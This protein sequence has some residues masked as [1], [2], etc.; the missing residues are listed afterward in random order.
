MASRPRAETST[1]FSPPVIQTPPAGWL[2]LL[3]LKS[4]GRQPDQSS[5]T[6][7]P[8]LEMLPFYLA[9]NRAQIAARTGQAAVA[10]ANVGVASQV[11]AGKIWLL[12]T[13]VFVS[14]AIGAVAPQSANVSISDA[15]NQLV[16]F[17][18]P[19]NTGVTG[20]VLIGGL[21]GIRILL[22]GYKISIWT[23]A[24]AAPTAYTYSWNVY[25]QEVAA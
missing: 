5:K 4:G 3:G 2:G 14:T 24:A 13:V 16:E 25:G 19:S 11:P 9:G 22:P 6:L 7:A 8:T 1:A 10:N 20:N 17:G 23:T 12:E 21:S 15:S 18:P